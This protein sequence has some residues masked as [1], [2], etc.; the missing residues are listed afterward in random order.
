MKQP[1]TPQRFKFYGK[2]YETAPDE[3]GKSSCYRCAF[4]HSTVHKCGMEVHEDA[5][6]APIA[7]CISGEHYYRE[8]KP[9]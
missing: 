5:D 6:G 1:F 3:K 2:S 8:A 7:S 9:A 4:L